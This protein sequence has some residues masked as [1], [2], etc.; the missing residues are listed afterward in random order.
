MTLLGGDDDERLEEF[1]STE[2][3]DVDKDLCCS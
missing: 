1:L 2:L 3:D